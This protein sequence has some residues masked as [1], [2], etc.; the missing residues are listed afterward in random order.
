MK[1]VYYCEKCGMGF[2][3]KE[4]CLD[5]ENSCN[6]KITFLCYK[7]GKVVDWFKCDDNATIK[8]NQCHTVNLGLMGYGSKFDGH[9]VIFDLCDDCL[10]D[11]INTF[12]YKDDVFI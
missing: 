7:C 4:I 9:S 1:I 8:E 11:F 5:H 3:T 2:E 10:C 12:R 6:E